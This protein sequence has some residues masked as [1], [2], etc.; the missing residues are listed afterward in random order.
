[1]H[2]EVYFSL[3]FFLFS[4]SSKRGWFSW[5]KSKPA[6][7]VEPAA[8]VEGD[9]GTD[10]AGEDASAPPLTAPP[11]GG[12]GAAFPPPA[13]TGVNPF[14]RRAGRRDTVQEGRPQPTEGG[15]TA[16]SQGP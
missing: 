4:K 12:S 9:R 11:P 13:S 5:F 6:S 16:L 3:F 8:Q 7:R 2:G 1:M 14:S 10:G 15:L